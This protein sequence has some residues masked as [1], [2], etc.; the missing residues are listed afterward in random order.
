MQNL[1]LVSWCFC[2]FVFD[3]DG[4]SCL[5]TF[6]TSK[7]DYSSKIDTG[8]LAVGQ[9]REGLEYESCCVV[10]YYFNLG[11]DV[12]HWFRLQTITLPV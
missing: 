7:D 4:P 10:E 3:V 2:E 5:S 11:K 6:L 12:L 8:T 9:F 1:I